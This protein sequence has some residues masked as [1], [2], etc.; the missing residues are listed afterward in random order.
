MIEI[1][2]FI[3]L[4]THTRYPDKNNFP[5]FEIEKAALNGGYSEV[6]AMANSEIT[7][8][9]IENLNLAR[10]FDKKLNIKV[11]RVGALSKNLDGKELVN[12]NEFVDE[13]VTIFSDDG[14]TLIDDDLSEIAFKKIAQLNAAIFQHCEKNCHTNPGDIAPPH[15]TSELITIHENEEFEIVKRDLDLVNK[16]K[17]RYHVQHVS[18]KKSV[19]LIKDAKENDLP[20]TAEVTPHHLLKNNLDINMNDGSLKMYPPLRS[21]ED[22]QA[23]INGLK[24]GIIDVIA[25]DHAP[26]PKETKEVSFKK[27]ARGVVGLE[28]AFVVL[29]SSNLFSLEELTRFMSINPMNILVSLGYDSSNTKKNSWSKND[30][31]FITKSFY[32]NSAFENFQVN[33]QKELNHV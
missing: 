26:H 5:I 9:S 24:N 20:V 12:F 7:I 23:L 1:P 6:L 17:T 2:S 28:S 21:E 33:I 32:K 16:Y 14:K 15:N 30:S 10:S 25:T 8:D 19:E 18:S 29:F 4:H 27:S 3:D 22:R 13:G 11:H 31:T